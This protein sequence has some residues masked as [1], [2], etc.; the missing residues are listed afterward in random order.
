MVT[1]AH[2]T[3]IKTLQEWILAM[4]AIADDPATSALWDNL[5]NSLALQLFIS[6]VTTV[7]V[8]IFY[9][10]LVLKAKA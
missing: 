8:H 9:D 3:S 1:I 10:F 2:S 7:F 6:F 5:V 4:S